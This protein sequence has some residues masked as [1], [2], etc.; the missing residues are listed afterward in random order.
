VEVGNL[1][2]ERVDVAG[3]RVPIVV[4]DIAVKIDGRGNKIDDQGLILY[5]C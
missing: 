5:I 3:A 2:R 1:S 4:V